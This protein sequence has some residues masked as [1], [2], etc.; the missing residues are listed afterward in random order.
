MIHAP[1]SVLLPVKS[2]EMLFADWC[3]WNRCVPMEQREG[4]GAEQRTGQNRDCSEPSQ[5]QGFK[6]SSPSSPL[7]ISRISHSCSALHSS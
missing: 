1:Q 7:W 6:T 4:T 3:A 2:G 5:A